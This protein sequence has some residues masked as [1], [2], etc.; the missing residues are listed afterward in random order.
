MVQVFESVVLALELTKS[1]NIKLKMR[2]IFFSL[3]I[4]IILGG[5]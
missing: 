5:I 3:V 4:L 1:S 2:G